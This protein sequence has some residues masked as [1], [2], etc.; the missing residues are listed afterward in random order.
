M[1]QS[2][3]IGLYTLS[4]IYMSSLKTHSAKFHSQTTYLLHNQ[5]QGQNGHF[6]VKSHIFGSP[7]YFED[8]III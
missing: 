4:G 2:S 6:T 5:L 8:T 1:D 3:H 7:S